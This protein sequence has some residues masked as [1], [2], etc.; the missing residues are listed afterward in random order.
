M[1]TL[2]Y[3]QVSKLGVVA[4]P[5][6]A[7]AG[8]DKVPVDSRGIVVFRNGDAASKTITV[9]TPGNDEYGQ[10]RPDYTVVVPAGQVAYI[11]PFSIDLGDAADDRLVAL[12]YSAVTSCTVDAVRY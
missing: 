12:T 1:A 3:R 6:N 8:G 11:G 5:A 7:S 4:N 9:A 2:A 10:A